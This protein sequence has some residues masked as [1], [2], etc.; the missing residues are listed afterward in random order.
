VTGPSSEE[1][2]A[3]VEGCPPKYNRRQSLRLV[4][5]E[6]KAV[7]CEALLVEVWVTKGVTVSTSRIAIITP[8]RDS[9]EL[10][11]KVYETGSDAPVLTLHIKAVAVVLVSVKYCVQP[12]EVHVGVVPVSCVSRTISISPVAVSGT[13]TTIVVPVV[14]VV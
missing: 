10:V 7:L 14:T 2:I 11:V 9:P 5:I 3:A 4:V 1:G 8:F 13:S 6:G 12:A